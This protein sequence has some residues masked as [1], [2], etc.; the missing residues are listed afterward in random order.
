MMEAQMNQ[1][2]FHKKHCTNHIKDSGKLYIFHYS[3]GLNFK[4]LTRKRLTNGGHKNTAKILFYSQ[5]HPT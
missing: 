5:N 1:W 2:L 4:L 3:G